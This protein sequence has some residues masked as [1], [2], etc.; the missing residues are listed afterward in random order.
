MYINLNIVDLQLNSAIIEFE[1]EEFA[2]KVFPNEPSLS[3]FVV[4]DVKKAK[5]FGKNPL[6]LPTICQGL[7]IGLFVCF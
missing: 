2:S 4:Y 3:S 7:K 1:W 5:M 6:H